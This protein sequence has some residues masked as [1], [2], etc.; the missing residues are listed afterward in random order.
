MEIYAMQTGGE[1]N[2]T[3]YYG[4]ARPLEEN[5]V[6]FRIVVKE[7]LTWKKNTLQNIGD[8]QDYQNTKA[9][10]NLLVLRILKF[11]LVFKGVIQ[12]NEKWEIQF[13]IN[14]QAWLF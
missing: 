5:C 9:I 13:K 12:W 8:S 1:R 11:Q 7:T 2:G 6:Q 3:R 14:G 10:G 4:N